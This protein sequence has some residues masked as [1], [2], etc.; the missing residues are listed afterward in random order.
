ML[1][2]SPFWSR[3]PPLP[4]AMRL[5][6]KPAGRPLAA[7]SGQGLEERRL[8]HVADHTT[9]QKFLI[10]T[11]AQV[12]VLPAARSERTLPAILYL[13]AVNGTRIPVY[14]QRSLTLNLGLRRLFR[15]V[16]LVADAGSAIIGADFLAK[17]GLLVDLR[18]KRLLDSAT[19][20]SV[21]GIA[22]GATTDVAP[23]CAAVAS[24]PFAALINEFP[25]LTSP[26]DWTQPVAHA[27]QHHIRPTC[28]LPSTA[29]CPRQAQSGP[30]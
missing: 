13:Q 4:V 23:S 10:D 11:G 30:C 7:T 17:H 14:A 9:G 1:L 12:S 25:S 21:Q 28:F 5:D 22:A 8:F 20:L 6:G 2:P 18:H 27:I 29:P 26:P 19:S 24:E 3:S 15:W 16:F